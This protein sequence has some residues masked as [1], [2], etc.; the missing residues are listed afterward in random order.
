MNFSRRTLG[1][2]LTVGL[3]ALLCSG[4]GGS[5][6][7]GGGGGERK[8]LTI[9]TAPVGG[10]FATVGSALSEV[11]ND[12]KGNNNWRCS[13]EGTKGSRD[14]II[15]LDKHELDFALSN[16]SITYFAVRGESG[17]DKK[18]NV[19][20]VM[21]LAPN[22]GV[23]ITTKDSP[24]KKLA[25]LKGQRVYVGPAGAGFEMF[26]GPILEAHGVSYKDFTPVNGPQ[27]DASDLLGDGSIAAAF[28][29]G[30]PPTGSIVQACSSLDIRFLPYDDQAREKLVKDYLCFKNYTLPAKTYSDQD[31]ELHVLNVGSM[32]LITAGDQDEE[33]VYQ[34][35][36]TL[37][38]NR[39]AMIEKHPNTGKAIEPNATIDTGTEFHPGAIRFYKEIG[40]WKESA[41]AGVESPE[42]SG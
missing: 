3:A 17:W 2:F 7:S 15:R 42:T 30:V 32:H 6:D 34:V 12:H 24:I 5:N 23:F 18:H 33:Q 40:V 13:P 36:K 20:A 14:N 9:G 8:F 27:S 28:L 38:E 41:A 16:A 10:A 26:L 35:T 19:K 21:T 25:D 4:C 11:L 31:E 29:G 37:Y 39:Q 1:C 22:V